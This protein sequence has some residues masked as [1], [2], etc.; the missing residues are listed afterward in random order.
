MITFKKIY[1]MKVRPRAT[2]VTIL[3]KHLDKSLKCL[4]IIYKSIM[5]LT[6]AI[7]KAKKIKQCYKKRHRHM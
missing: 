5:Q 2:I 4:K 6:R 7:L 3:V 1:M